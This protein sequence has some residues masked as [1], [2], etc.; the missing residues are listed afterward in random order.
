ML[1]TYCFF[2]NVHILVPQHQGNKKIINQEK[3]IEYN[4]FT[5]GLHYTSLSMGMFYLGFYLL[6]KCDMGSLAVV[7]TNIERKTVTF[8]KHSEILRQRL[9]TY[10]CMYVCIVC[11][12]VHRSYL[13]G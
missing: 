2:V 4:I 7:F 8:H 9:N 1:I 11:I 5:L 12:Y 10:V 6:L 13:K 3:Q